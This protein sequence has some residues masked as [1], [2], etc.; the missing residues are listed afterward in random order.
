MQ[1]PPDLKALVPDRTSDES[2]AAQLARRLRESIEDG[3]FRAGTR[4][5]SSRQLARRLGLARNTVALAFEQLAA[6]GYLQSRVGAGTFVTSPARAGLQRTIA[7]ERAQRIVSLRPD[8]DLV[9]GAGALSP[10]AADFSFFPWRTWDECTR[11]ELQSNAVKDLRYG[12][13]S[14]LDSLKQ[15][16]AA[17]V[18][19]F[20][21]VIAEPDN[22]IIV[23][24]AQAALLLASLVLAGPSDTVVIEDPC[25]SPARVAFQVRGLRCRP[26]P[27][28]DDG[29]VVDQ[30]LDDAAFA[31]VT[32][33]HQFPLGFVLS[34]QRRHQLLSWAHSRKAYIIEDDCDGAF[35]FVSRPLPALQRLDP[36]R[37]IYIGTFNKTL[38]P[39]VRLGYVISPPHLTEAFRIAR[40]FTNLGAGLNL[41]AT[42]AEFITAGHLTR[43]VRRMREV[44]ER[45]RDVLT[46]TLSSLLGAAFR[47]GPIQAGLHAALLAPTGFDDVARSMLPDGQR[48]VALSTLCIR[49]RD[50]RG[51]VLGFTQ[52][53]EA[54]IESAAH[55]VAA[56]C[57]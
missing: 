39:T 43:Y 27:V 33:S 23:G 31:Y 2:L 9:A 24:G 30:L 22:V 15:A 41:Q 21:G 20:R 16:I 35:T 5:L 57:G 34:L 40:S 51:F 37:V 49:Q 45:R 47:L 26:V 55:S 12:A 14:G 48:L 25:Y 32:P 10:G 7:P 28:D 6:E 8:F 42:V 17:H 38:P 19:H 54:A 18:H 56:I 3:T 1:Q 4:L 13:S 36:E 11:N 46:K 44:Y 29:M 53:D 52:G 50:R